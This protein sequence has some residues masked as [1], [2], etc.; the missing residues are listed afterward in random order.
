MKFKFNYYWLLLFIPLIFIFWYYL[1]LKENKPLRVLNFYGPKHALPANDT[2]YHVVIDFEFINQYNQKTTKKT[3]ANKIYV[4]EFFFTTCKSICPIMNTNLEKVYKEFEQDSTVL[5]LSHTVD[6]ETDSVPTLLQYARNRG[7]R[8]QRWLFLTGSKKQLYDVARRGYL[9][10]A[11]AGD[12]GADDFIHTQNFALVDK[13]SH[14]RGFY[15]G[16]DSLEINR[17]IREI[18]L[19]EKEYDYKATHTH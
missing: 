17:L 15:D 1:A 16:T 11:E 18:K 6:P 9:L 13:E 2:A 8:D 5:I 14:L 3:T 12:G 10:N 4:C 7:V 19:L